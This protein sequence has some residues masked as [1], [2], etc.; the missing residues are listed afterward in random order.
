MSDCP[1]SAT[2]IFFNDKMLN[3]PAMA[4]MYKKNYCKGDFANC[5]RYMVFTSLGKEK[6]A[7]D[8]F[9][10]MKDTAFKIISAG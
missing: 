7:A 9:P 10:N 4:E 2:C 5:A 6:V 8:L 1:N 3:M